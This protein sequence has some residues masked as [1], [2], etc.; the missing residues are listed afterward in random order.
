VSGVS[1]SQAVAGEIS[2]ASS[3]LAARIGYDSLYVLPGRQVGSVTNAFHVYAATQKNTLRPMVAAF[4]LQELPGCCGVIVAFHVN[5]QAAFQGKGLGNGLLQ[6]RMAVAKQAGYTLMQATTV[7]GNERE[8][9]LLEK[10]GFV[11]TTEFV[12]RRTS[13]AVVVWQKTLE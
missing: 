10:N 11:R 1:I 8:A 4:S 9:H 13:N 5:V 7:R 3:A 12:S 6:V 2:A